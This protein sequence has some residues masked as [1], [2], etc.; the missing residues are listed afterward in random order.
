[1]RAGCLLLCPFIAGCV[2]VY[3]EVAATNYSGGSISPSGGGASVS[4]GASSIGFN[5]GADFGN[6]KR[7]FALGYEK[8]SL[9][10]DNGSA[11]YGASSARFDF[12]VL[13]ISKKAHVRLGAAFGFGSGSSTFAGMTR[14]DAG[15]GGAYAGAGFTYFVNWHL[16]LHAMV[17]AS[18]A[19]VQ[20]PD[21]NSFGGGGVTFRLAATYQ[22]SDVRQDIRHL[23]PLES[24]TDITDVL[25]G[26]AQKLGCHTTRERRSTYAVLNASCDG[27]DIE[28]FQIAEGISVTCHDSFEDECDARVKAIIASA[29]TTP[30]APPVAQPAAAPATPPPPAPM[31]SP[32]PAPVPTPAP[33]PTAAPSTD[34]T[35]P[36]EPSTSRSTP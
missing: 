16:G 29:K 22:L 1:M 32:A 21:S 10:L 14:S 13:S 23:E 24:S 7:R 2:G 30:A 12:N 20:L 28:F 25:E 5:V 26:G 18:Y 3:A 36:A 27:N 11:N 34:Q 35:A 8:Q 15:G 4:T 6:V 31:P 33:E 19:A 9:T 17:G